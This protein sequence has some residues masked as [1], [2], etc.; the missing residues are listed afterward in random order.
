MLSDGDG[1]YLVLHKDP[2]SKDF[3]V[4]YGDGK[5]F[6]T[7]KTKGGGVSKD[8]WYRNFWS[9]R[10]ER[11]LL[12]SK[13]GIWR[14]SCARDQFTTLTELGEVER[15]KVLNKAKFRGRLFDRSLVLL[16]RDEEA[17]YYVLD[18]AQ[19]RWN[20]KDA[21]ALRDVQVFRG[22]A[23]KMR[24]LKIKELAS[25]R[26]GVVA[27]TKPGTLVLERDTKGNST[28]VWVVKKKGQK[29][30]TQLRV[31]DAAFNQMLVFATLGIYP[32]RLGVPC[33]DF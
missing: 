32:E 20:V 8:G 1:H 4:F 7:V 21:W 24:K 26:E 27:L 10:A 11:S 18:A 14:V 17:N 31:L 2:R 16:A 6:H 13:S 3:V 29:E 19:I 22:P 33:D 15:R 25:D 30:R 12:E 9:P 28:A 23:G 5:I